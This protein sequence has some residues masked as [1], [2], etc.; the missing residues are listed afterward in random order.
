MTKKAKD[1][2]EGAKKTTKARL[3]EE[4]LRDLQAKSAGKVKGGIPVQID[5]GDRPMK[6]R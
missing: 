4:T 2:R 1:T 3:G 5:G 6:P